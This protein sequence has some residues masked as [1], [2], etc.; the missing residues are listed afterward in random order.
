MPGGQRYESIDE[1]AH[2]K[3]PFCTCEDPKCKARKDIALSLSGGGSR[4][5]EIAGVAAYLIERGNKVVNMSGCSAGSIVT[6]LLASGIALGIP[7]EKFLGAL[8]DA[9]NAPLSRWPW[10]KKKQLFQKASLREWLEQYWD[11]CE[12]SWNESGRIRNLVAHAIRLC[13]PCNEWSPFSPS[14]SDPWTI[15]M[16]IK[17]ALFTG[18]NDNQKSFAET[19][20]IFP[21]YFEAGEG[22][23]TNSASCLMVDAWNTQPHQVILDRDSRFYDCLGPHYEEWG[24][25]SHGKNAALAGITFSS[26]PSD[27]V[28]YKTLDVVSASCSIPALMMPVKMTLDP[29]NC[30]VY[31]DPKAAHDCGYHSPPEPFAAE[32]YDGGLWQTM[33]IGQMELFPDAHMDAMQ[34]ITLV[35]SDNLSTCKTHNVYTPYMTN[36]YSKEGK[37]ENWKL[38][39]FTGPWKVKPVWYKRHIGARIGNVISTLYNCST[40]D[41]VV[42][43]YRA[44]E[45]GDKSNLAC[46]DFEGAREILMADHKWGL[47]SYPSTVDVTKWLDHSGIEDMPD[48]RTMKNGWTDKLMV[49]DVCLGYL[50]ADLQNMG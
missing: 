36:V 21:E 44:H 38:R 31:R 7:S 26:R 19:A 27:P 24:T 5:G 12:V 40:W 20:K 29:K 9:L 39:Y 4:Y 23:L 8:E 22:W 34:G 6:C 11:L 32:F 49:T 2:L 30:Q 41:Q 37:R 10:K 18:V 14:W 16:I 42:D 3:N 45:Y 35:D 28:R 15:T 48:S 13:A 46:T 33:P 47:D 50:S 25:L 17:T 43:Q 1:E